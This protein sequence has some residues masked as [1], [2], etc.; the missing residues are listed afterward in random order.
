MQ[1]RVEV[2]IP[3]PVLSFCGQDNLGHMLTLLKQD[4]LQM[5]VNVMS[6]RLCGPNK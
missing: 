6:Q 2:K 5:G 1:T 3:V 4:I